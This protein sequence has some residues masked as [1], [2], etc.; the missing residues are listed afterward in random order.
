MEMN[1][2]K[3]KY[4]VYCFVDPLG[5]QQLLEVSCVAVDADM[6]KGIIA[7]TIPK[8]KYGTFD[9][10]NVHLFKMLINTH[11]VKQLMIFKNL[12][13]IEHYPKNDKYIEI[14]FKMNDIL[15]PFSLVKT[16]LDTQFYSLAQEMYSTMYGTGTI[17]IHFK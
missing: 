15:T 8:E 14:L 5:E 11:V 3:T 12:K 9:S 4:I 1:Q 7:I 10:D 6:K 16:G 13:E 17:F 2:N